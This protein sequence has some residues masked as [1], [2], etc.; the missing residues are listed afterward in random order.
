MTTLKEIVDFILSK[1]ISVSLVTPAMMPS[2][3]R[4]VAEDDFSDVSV[5]YGVE[6][7]YKSD[8]L[9][10]CESEGQI[11][12]MTRYGECEELFGTMDEVVKKLCSENMYWWKVTCERNPRSTIAF[13]GRWLPL[14][15]EHGFVKPIVETRYV[16][17]K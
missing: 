4:K 14:L 7:F 13:D 9:Y 5:W 3:A 6:G 11:H 12:Y 8:K 16:A 15:V 10:I 17:A 2:G 1:N